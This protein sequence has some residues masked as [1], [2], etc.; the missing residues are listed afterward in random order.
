M[1][2]NRKKMLEL[3]RWLERYLNPDIKARDYK[4]L[5]K[6]AIGLYSI[7]FKL[8][9]ND[10]TFQIV[11]FI[12]KQPEEKRQK[13]IDAVKR[14]ALRGFKVEDLGID[15]SEFD[16]FEVQVLNNLRYQL[17]GK[18]K[19][20]NDLISIV[21][22]FINRNDFEKRI[23]D[24]FLELLRKEP[25]ASSIENKTKIIKDALSETSYLWWIDPVMKEISNIYYF[26]K[27]IIS[28]LKEIQTDGIKFN[29]SVVTRYN[30][31]RP[32]LSVLNGNTL[33][34][35]QK[36]SSN[37]H[38]ALH[39]DEH[40]SVFPWAVVASKICIDFLMVDGQAHIGF[41]SHCDRFIVCDRQKPDGTL[42]R[43]FCSPRCRTNSKR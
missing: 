9:E 34:I 2:S 31:L 36:F 21:N 1:A 35:V 27:S 14:S 22:S 38:H 20:K 28:F 11:E 18:T 24:A 23:I 12:E 5:A 39:T 3:G 17:T 8:S 26:P 29:R 42:E 13:Y 25:K 6:E 19:E 33:K 43:E 37:Y 10:I 4:K 7:D 16:D 15:L 30:E 40:P 32:T 41:C